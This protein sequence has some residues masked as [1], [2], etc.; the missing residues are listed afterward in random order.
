MSNRVMEIVHE[1]FTTFGD[2]LEAAAIKFIANVR[3]IEKFKD[4]E[5]DVEAFIHLI[6]FHETRIQTLLQKTMT[7][8]IP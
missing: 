6:K 3:E 4:E 1:S 7:D 8:F 2:E 5:T